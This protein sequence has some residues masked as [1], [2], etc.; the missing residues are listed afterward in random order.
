MIR[1][2]ITITIITICNLHLFFQIIE[3]DDLVESFHT[4]LPQTPVKY[5]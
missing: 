3:L 4:F 5:V 2:Q 1:I